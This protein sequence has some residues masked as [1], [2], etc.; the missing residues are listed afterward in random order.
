MEEIRSVIHNDRYTFFGIKIQ[1][2][3]RPSQGV[4]LGCVSEG[5][6]LGAVQQKGLAVEVVLQGEVGPVAAAEVRV[7]GQLGAEQPGE[8]KHV[9]DLSAGLDGARPLDAHVVHRLAG[10]DAQGVD[11]VA[12]YQ[13]PCRE[14]ERER[15][16]ERGGCAP[17]EGKEGRKL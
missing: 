7:L 15:E 9:L 1:V 16:R 12:G 11:Q 5:P 8:V 4:D 2:Y 6:R 14:R 17:R 3:Q 13:D 10:T